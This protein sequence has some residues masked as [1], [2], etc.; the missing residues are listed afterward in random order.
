MLSWVVPGLGLLC[1]LIALVWVRR[2]SR[3]LDGLKQSYWELRYEYTKLRS[4]L[5]RLDPDEA[6]SGDFVPAAP[7]ATP[8]VSFVPLSTIRRKDK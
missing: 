3:S 5:S 1:A 4:Q 8:S 7:P 6:S 2:L